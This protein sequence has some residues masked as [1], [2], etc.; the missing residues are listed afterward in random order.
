M[1]DAVLEV[2]INILAAGKLRGKSDRDRRKGWMEASTSKSF[3]V[4]PQVDELKKLVKS[5][6]AEMEKLKLEGRKNYR[7][8]QN[9]DNRGNFR[10]PNNAPR[11]L[12]RDQRNMDRDDQKFQAPLQK[13]LVVDE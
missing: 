2:E 9:V 4:H 6:S 13:N 1:Q 3:V 7:N 5:L 10:R 12:P 8:T 11:V